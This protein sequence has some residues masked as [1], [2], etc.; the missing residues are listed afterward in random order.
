MSF[1]ILASISKAIVSSGYRFLKIAFVFVVALSF[2]ACTYETECEV[3]DFGEINLPTGIAMSDEGLIVANSNAEYQYC[4]G[5]LTIHDP[6]TGEPTDTIPM[7][8]NFLGQEEDYSFL[9]DVLVD[10]YQRYAFVTSREAN[11]IIV[12]DITAPPGEKK[13]ISVIDAGADPFSLMYIPNAPISSRFLQE[14]R[15]PDELEFPPV[16]RDLVVAANLATSDLTVIDVE[17]IRPLNW[18]WA[19]NRNEGR[20][21]MPLTGIFK[22]TGMAY[23]EEQNQIVIAGQNSLRIGLVNVEEFIS[24]YVTSTFG[25]ASISGSRGLA[26]ANG[27]DPSRKYA[28][29]SIRYPSGIQRLDLELFRTVEQLKFGY[30]PS[31]VLALPSGDELLVSDP[32]E[33][34]LFRISVNPL[35][36]TGYAEIG[37]SAGKVILSDDGQAAFVVNYAGSISRID[38]QTMFSYHF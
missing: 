14:E 36:V 26:L 6:Q 37:T 10:P 16:N 23:W 17:T 34:K 27:P 2:A 22:P 32:G 15:P 18:R 25:T 1:M 20:K 7:A 29:F 5:Y 3:P 24:F 4:Y 9:G 28:Y 12:V 13:I 19:E 8:W 11:A 21:E 35:A 33:G 38:L 31:S 30:S